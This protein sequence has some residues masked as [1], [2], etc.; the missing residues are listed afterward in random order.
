MLT[1]K[2]INRLGPDLSAGTI[3]E[4]YDLAGHPEY[5][6]SHSAVI[7]SLCLESPAVF[8]LMV[9]LTKPENQLSKEIY[10]WSNFIGI[11]SST[12]S[13]RVIVV[14]SRKDVLSL[15]SQLFESK[16]KFAEDTA[17]DALEKECFAAWICGF[18]QS[19]AFF[20]EYQ[21]F[22]QAPNTKHLK[23]FCSRSEQDELFLPSA[24]CIL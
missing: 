18:G 1:R 5:Y 8:V 24:S 23:G 15:D 17:K 22:S 11:E 10:K 3:I 9:D 4:I 12:I 14:G 2:S 16:C 13:S 6:S 21:T 7:E 19:S 20:R